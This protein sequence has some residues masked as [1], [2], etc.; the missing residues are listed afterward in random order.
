MNKRVVSII[1][2]IAISFLNLGFIKLFATPQIK[3]IAVVESIRPATVTT[4]TV[5]TT[6]TTP[7]TTRP[8]KYP[9]ARQVWDIMKSYGWSDIICAGIMGNMM[10]ECGGD[11]LALRWDAVNRSGGHYGLCQWSKKYYPEIWGGS[12]EE[13]L[14]YLRKTLDIGMFNKCKTPQEAAYIFSKYY[15]RP[16]QV[17][18][19][20]KRRANAKTAYN[21]FSGYIG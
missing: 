11:T 13:Q 6:T 5:T 19:S 1:V 3:E 15:E 2:V 10:R 7:T 14:E 21:Y 9:I 12:I 16:A 18:P 4:T 20:G 8:E 17:D